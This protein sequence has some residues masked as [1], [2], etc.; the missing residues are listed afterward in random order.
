MV[1]KRD[2][3]WRKSCETIYSELEGMKDRLIRLIDGIEKLSPDLK[4]TLR[5]VIRHLDEIVNTIEWKMDIFT[6]VCPFDFSG[7]HKEAQG[8][9]SVPVFETTEELSPGYVGG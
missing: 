8:G 7:Y 4:E 3:D 9:S 1:T 2:I 5:P 6:K